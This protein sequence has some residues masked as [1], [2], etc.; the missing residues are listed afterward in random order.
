MEKLSRIRTKVEIVNIV[1]I[2]AQ[3]QKILLINLL[4]LKE[5]G[6]KAMETGVVFADIINA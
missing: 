4:P 3:L 6:L 2:V 1:L 5:I